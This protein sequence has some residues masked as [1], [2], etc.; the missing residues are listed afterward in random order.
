VAKHPI[1]HN[2]E[3]SIGS[4]HSSI[5]S[6]NREAKSEQRGRNFKRKIPKV[7]IIYHLPP[8]TRKNQTHIQ[9][10]KFIIRTRNFIN[11]TNTNSAPFIQPTNLIP[12]SVIRNQNNQKSNTTP[13][14]ES[15]VTIRKNNTHTKN[16]KTKSKRRDETEAKRRN[17]PSDIQ[18]PI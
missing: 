9:N 4:S 1:V 13:G 6:I 3:L 16:P 5:I 14:P 18:T 7:S 12:T 17:F 15:T 10:Q 2:T 11:R 8:F